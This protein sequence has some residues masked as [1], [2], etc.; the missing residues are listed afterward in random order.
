MFYGNFQ[1][2]ENPLAFFTDLKQLLPNYLTSLNANRFLSPCQSG[3]DAEDWYELLNATYQQ[4]VHLI[5]LNLTLPSRLL[6]KTDSL[7]SAPLDAAT[8]IIPKTS[9]HST[10]NMTTITTTTI[11][12]TNTTANTIYK[13]NSNAGTPDHR[14]EDE[15][16]CGSPMAHYRYGNS[17]I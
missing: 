4:F 11:P 10:M 1:P 13:T 5:N 2:R 14:A 8:L 17:R 15:Y 3:S 16:K 7:T 6:L 9:A 12:M